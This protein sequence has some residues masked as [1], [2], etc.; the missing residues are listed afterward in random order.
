[1]IGPLHCVGCGVRDPDHVAIDCPRLPVATRLAAHR[2]NVVRLEEAASVLAA[3]LED[4]RAGLR[5]VE[6][7]AHAHAAGGAA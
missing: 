3:R 2:R 7:E 1:V 5:R 4:A 6:G